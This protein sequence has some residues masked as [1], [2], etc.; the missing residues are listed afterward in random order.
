MI[1]TGNRWGI[2]LSL[3]SHNC[4]HKLKIVHA[5]AWAESDLLV[6]ALGEHLCF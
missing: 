5:V 4:R 2:H 6:C 1:Q 3:C